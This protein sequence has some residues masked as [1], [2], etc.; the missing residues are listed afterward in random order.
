ME[1]P[2]RH[3]LLW[4][5]DMFNSHDEEHCGSLGEFEVRRLMKYMGA[6]AMSSLFVSGVV[7]Y[8]PKSQA[9]A[10]PGKEISETGLCLR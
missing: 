9:F 1:L 6:S 4:I 3:E 10:M 7:C 5:Y 8:G 2:A